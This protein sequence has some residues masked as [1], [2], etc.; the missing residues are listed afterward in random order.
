MVFNLSKKV[1]QQFKAFGLPKK[2]NRHIVTL[3]RTAKIPKRFL[4]TTVLLC[5]PPKTVF[6]LQN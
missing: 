1:N 2:V 6:L 5:G 4:K 3:N